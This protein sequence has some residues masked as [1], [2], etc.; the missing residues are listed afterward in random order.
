MI[1][2]EETVAMRLGRLGE[3]HAGKRE[4]KRVAQRQRSKWQTNDNCDAFHCGQAANAKFERER[5]G[6]REPSKFYS[7]TLV[8]VSKSHLHSRI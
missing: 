7:R 2:V 8:E 4:G 5:R 3:I 6:A 1:I